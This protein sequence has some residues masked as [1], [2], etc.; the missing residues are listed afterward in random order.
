[1]DYKQECVSLPKQDR[2]EDPVLLFTGDVADK[3]AY[4]DNENAFLRTV[5]IT[6]NCSTPGATLYYTTDGFSV[7]GKGSLSLA[8]GGRLEWSE[9]GLTTFRVVATAEGFYKSGVIEKGV[10]VVAPKTDEHALAG[11]LG[12]GGTQGDFVLFYLGGGG[13]G[14]VGLGTCVFKFRDFWV[15]FS[16]PVRSMLGG[17]GGERGGGEGGRRWWEG[18]GRR[19]EMG[20]LVGGVEF[21]TVSLSFSLSLSS[22]R[23]PNPYPRSRPS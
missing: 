6:M 7:P 11:V 2:V 3:N 19:G 14:G 18:G 12:P 20:G 23:Y 22:F 17:E 9:E 16:A 1:M 4:P 5:S 15:F 21:V 13:S 8:P 10:T